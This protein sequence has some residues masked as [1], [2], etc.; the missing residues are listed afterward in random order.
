VRKNAKS[1]SFFAKAA[2]VLNSEDIEALIAVRREGSLSAAAKAQN[3]VISTLSRRITALEAATGL[4]LLDRRADGSKLTLAG[5]QIAALAEPLAQELERVER[6]V[7]S[8]RAGNLKRPVRVSATEFVA[9]ELLAPALPT[10]WQRGADFPVHLQSQFDIVSL[11]GREADLAIRMTRPEGASLFVTKL[12]DVALA[13]YASRDYLKGR[14][15][16]KIDLSRERLIAYEETKATLPEVEW[17]TRLNLHD[18]VVVRSSSMRTQ[19][20]AAR[21]GAGIALLSVP[22]ANREPN[23]VKLPIPVPVT[24]RTPWLTVHRDMR[25]V[26]SIRRVHAWIIETF[27]ALG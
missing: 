13:F 12:P 5:E 22:F 25:R 2:A 1:F 4:A 7:E 18:A 20:N 14:S 6:A 17:I 23:L 26:S 10:L 19:M 21:H 9:S 3:L 16:S 27:K 11:A 8:L 24:P 15:V